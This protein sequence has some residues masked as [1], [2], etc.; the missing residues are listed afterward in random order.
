MEVL[1]TVQ[2][3]EKEAFEMALRLIALDVY[4]YGGPSKVEKIFKCIGYKIEDNK[5]FL[6]KYSDKCTKFAYDFNIQQTIDFAWGWYESN[7]KPTGNEPD[8]DGST[9]V[10]FRITTEKCGVGSNDWG[11]FA[12]IE[13]IWFIYGK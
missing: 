1:V 6:S 12:S 4:S 7:K 5:L 2:N 9:E 3:T 13:P 8:T 10:A 11:M